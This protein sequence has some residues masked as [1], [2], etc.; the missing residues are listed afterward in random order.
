[1]TDY[2]ITCTTK[3][4]PDNDRRIDALGG[5]K[6]PTT[7]IDKVIA[8]IEAKTHR[9]WTTADG[10]S[11]WIEVQTRKATGAKF[12]TTEGDGYPPNNLLKLPDCP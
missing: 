2:Q 10:K 9:F 7:A 4:G 6:F 1:M 5:P 8:L 3:D 12:L 11:V